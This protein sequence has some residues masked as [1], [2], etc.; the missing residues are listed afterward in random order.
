MWCGCF[1][2]SGGSWLAVHS[3]EDPRVPDGV[4]D[5]SIVS[6]ILVEEIILIDYSIGGT[7]AY[8]VQSFALDGGPEPSAERVAELKAKVEEEGIPV[9]YPDTE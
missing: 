1:Y 6:V 7:G 9:G 5:L 4:Y 3:S 2:G 8:F